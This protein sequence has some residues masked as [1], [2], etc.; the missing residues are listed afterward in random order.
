ML[1]R[2]GWAVSFFL[3]VPMAFAAGQPSNHKADKQSV[4]AAPVDMTL[5]ATDGSSLDLKSLRGKPVLIDMWATWCS[6]CLG[7]L[8]WLDEVQ[9]LLKPTGFVT[10]GVDYDDKPGSAKAFLARRRVDWPAFHWDREFNSAFPHKG[11]PHVVL[12]DATGTVVYAG[13]GLKQ[14]ALLVAIRKLGPEYAAALP[15]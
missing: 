6:L 4:A 14:D 2:F 1:R 3:Y 5:H 10:I 13:D 9:A 8:V 12:L 11:I 7:E 15:K